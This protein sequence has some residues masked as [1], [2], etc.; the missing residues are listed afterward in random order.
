MSFAVYTKS[1]QEIRSQFR[2][3]SSAVDIE[4]AFFVKESLIADVM[5]KIINLSKNGQ[6][7]IYIL[8]SGTT[9]KP[10]FIHKPWNYICDIHQR[11]FYNEDFR[12][13]IIN[14]FEPLSFAS[15][16]FLGISTQYEGGEFDLLGKGDKHRNQLDDI[17][18]I[19]ATPTF[20]TNYMMKF[21]RPEVRPHAIILGGETVTQDFIDRCKD[22]FNP[23]R[24]IHSYASTEFG[25]VLRST[26]SKAGYLPNQVVKP[27]LQ[28]EVKDGKLMIDGYDSGDL[29]EMRD[30]RIFILGRDN[31]DVINVGGRKI[32]ASEIQDK[33][34]KI[35]GVRLSCVTARKSPVVGQ[36]VS[37]TVEL[38]DQKDEVDTSDL[39]L[40]LI[41]QEVAKNNWPKMQIKFGQVQVNSNGKVVR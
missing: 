21:D 16:Q 38:A 35:L 12:S 3:W 41:N 15:L 13:K 5:E 2:H 37:L 1:F 8:T 24:I 27:Y 40:E 19:A 23:E 31:G 32:S 10:K 6:D 30:G 4:K 28:V 11:N 26:D 25:L 17:S 9:G 39:T 18:S 14:C 34:N 36:I 22:F 7:G 33:I 20:L 29:A